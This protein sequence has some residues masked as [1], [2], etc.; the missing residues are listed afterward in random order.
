LHR[1]LLR[2]E[3]FDTLI[4]TPGKLEMDVARLWVRRA[5]SRS[6]LLRGP[7]PIVTQLRLHIRHPPMARPPE[8]L[9]R[10]DWPDSDHIIKGHVNP[11]A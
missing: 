3:S 11:L 4:V 2:G 9:V 6:A 5:R 1:T 7:T 10:V 8:R